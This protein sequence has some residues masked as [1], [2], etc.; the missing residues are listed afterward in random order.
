MRYFA[1]HTVQHSM[2]MNMQMVIVGA[3]LLLAIA[4]IALWRR[5]R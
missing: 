2:E 3:A 5:E 1:H 4:V